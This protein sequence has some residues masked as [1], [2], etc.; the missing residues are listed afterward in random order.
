MICCSRSSEQIPSQVWTNC[1]GTGAVLLSLLGGRH[2]CHKKNCKIKSDQRESRAGILET[3]FLGRSIPPKM[4]SFAQVG[5]GN[6]LQVCFCAY[7]RPGNTCMSVA[8]APDISVPT[9]RECHKE[10]L[11][12]MAAVQGQTLRYVYDVTS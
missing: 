5:P 6:V 10:T 1:I 12:D 3:C 8:Q 4:S 2:A 7:P 9:S 11:V